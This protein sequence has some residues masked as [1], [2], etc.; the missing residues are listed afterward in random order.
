MSDHVQVQIQVIQ[1]IAFVTKTTVFAFTF[2]ACAD[3]DLRN[4]E[5]KRE[6]KD[7]T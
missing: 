6:C 5:T 3:F 4:Q 7:I 1:D 2:V